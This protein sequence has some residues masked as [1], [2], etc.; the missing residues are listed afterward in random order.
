MIRCSSISKIMTKPRSK[1]DPWSETAKTAMLDAVREELFVVRKSLDD[2]KCIQKGKACEDLG[3]ELYNDVFMYD[4]EKLPANSRRNNGIITGEPDLIAASSK[5]GV[6]I[7]VAWSLLTFPLT[8]EQAG[9]KDYEWQARG[10]M[11]LFDLP[12]WEIAYCA[13]DTPEELLKPWD[14]RDHH[15]IDDAIPLHHRITIATFTRDMEIEKAM[16]D[17][18]AAANEWIKLAIKEFATNHDEYIK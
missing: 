2:V 10:Y 12:A 11:C 7:K 18:C 15:I 1:T 13:I 5:K 9:K 8:E 6:D 14:D 17:K 4:L 3:V 16:L